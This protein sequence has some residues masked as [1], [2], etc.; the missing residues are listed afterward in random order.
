M[1]AL[2]LSLKDIR[3]HD[4]VWRRPRQSSRQSSRLGRRVAALFVLLALALTFTG[5]ANAAEAVKGELNVITE[6]GYARLVFRFDEEVEAKVR[7]SGPIMVITFMKPVDVAVD[8]IKAG[9]PDF[10]SMAR[11]DPDGS[12]IRIAL[13]RKVKF[14]VLT[15]AER[16]YVD[17]VPETWQGLMPGLPQEVVVELARRTRDAERQLHKEQLA[18]KLKKPALIRVKV[19]R[20]PTF[21]R[22][23]F[24]MPDTANVVP[25]RTEAKL[26]LN[27]DQPIKWDLADAKASMPP[28]LESIEAETESESAA[29]TFTLNGKPVVRTF[30]EDHSIVVDV[31]LDGA[32]PKEAVKQETGEGIAQAAAA[33]ATVPVIAP[34]ETVPAKDAPISNQPPKAAAPPQPIDAVAPPPKPAAPPVAKAAA[35]EPAK[36]AENS[37]AAPAPPVAPAAQREAAPMA[38][39]APEKVAPVV[40]TPAPEVAP[41][42]A[43]PSEAPKAATAGER[44]PPAPNP[45]GAV[46]VAIN[47]SGDN[48][49]LEFPF[50]LPTPAAVFR[51][52]DMLWLV[53]DSAAK[54]DLA[55]LTTDSTQVI[56]SAKLERGQDGE[57]IVRIRLERPRLASLDT[58]GPGWVVNIS[59]TVTVPTRP[60]GIARSIAGKGRASIAIPFADARKIHML[61]DPDIGDRLMVITALGPARGFLKPQD[62]VE[63]RALPSTHG[64][65]VQPIADDISAEIAID[66]ITISRPGGLSLSSTVIGSQ[67]QI[68]PSFRSLTFDTQVWGFDRQAKFTDRQSEL[69]RIAAAAPESKRRPARLNLARFYLACDMAAEAKA[70]L[71]VALA[72]QRGSEDITGAVLKAVANVLLGRPDE[73]LKELSNPVIGNQ[74]DAPIW[75]AVAHARQGKW[76]EA[77]D[78]F[79]RV[80]AAMGAL[81]IEL[82]RVAMQQSLRSSIEVRDFPGAARMVNEFETIGVPPELEAAIAVL[83]GRLY[84]GMGRSDDAL[85][86]YRNAA[87][88]RDRRAAAQ[89]RLREIVQL[90]AANDMTRKDVIYGLET[91]TTVW[92]GDETEVEGLKML[93]HLYTEDA[94]YRDAFHT[95]RTAMMAHPNSDLTRKIQDEAAVTFDSLF[96]AGKGDALPPVEALGLFYDFR[97]LTPVGRRGDEM[98]RRLAD[99]LVSV[100]LLDQAAELL[101]HQVDHRLQ[102]A[103]RAQ[104][105]TRLATIYLMNR[106]PDRALASLQKT[107]VADLSNE[108]RD[109][110]LLLEA[111][112]LSDIGRHDLAMELITNINSREAIRLRSDI[113]WA[114]RHWSLAAEQVELLFGERWREFTPLNDSERADILRAAIGFAL[115]EDSIGLVRLREKYAAKMA[116]GPDRRAFDLV[117]APIGTSGVEFQDV[118]KKVANI[119]TLDAFLRDMRARYPD[120]APIAP[121]DAAAKDAAAPAIPAKPN[122][123]M[124]KAATPDKA[125]FNAPGKPDAAS[126]PLPPIAPAGTPRKPDLSPTGSIL[127]RPAKPRTDTRANTR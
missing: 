116:D 13:T 71:D 83:V 4:R 2:P 107:R 109:Q 22:Y 104:V 95:M 48:L 93:A 86:N 97:E 59:D 12:A 5:S 17:I 90:F 70:V 72:D 119:N 27:F 75:R 35:P 39:A 89:G 53:F 63:L 31:G 1:T 30:R 99:R 124:P 40:A 126:S 41:I 91:L 65:V 105:A 111:R 123:A 66:K 56:R 68:A 122:G 45:D 32:K 47:R 92:R 51:R 81:P 11:R 15:A 34:P 87:A 21:T 37:P 23:V 96:L 16:L 110:R 44:V 61:N 85:T 120:A 76:P 78:G 118:A 117:S 84:E 60:L 115:G 127:P 79:K 57:A 36:A 62:F 19:A 94:R 42:A 125:I 69:I 14:N 28:T 43:A 67:Q 88:S 106:K 33:P 112:A 113:L 26:T 7:V 108:L 49:R 77:R 10:V 103:G 64:V 101:Q 73:A 55:A 20:Q 100:D 54:I 74:Q 25:E 9:A 18:T 102:G 38:V 58:E 121:G 82:Q 8:R 50:V 46:V 24:D 80:E 98:I 6:G 52:A 3:A 29:V 114:A